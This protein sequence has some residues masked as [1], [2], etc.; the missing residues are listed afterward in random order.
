VDDAA[1]PDRSVAEVCRDYG[2][3]R[4]TGYKWIKRHEQQGE[5][6]LCNRSRRPHSRPLE[7]TAEMA[8]RVIELRATLACTLIKAHPMKVTS[9]KSEPRGLVPRDSSR[10][11]EW[12]APA[13]SVSLRE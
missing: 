9:A 4:K 8:M 2:I 13:P 1:D 11:Y 3:S 5:L 7:T 6:G 10:W 12:Q